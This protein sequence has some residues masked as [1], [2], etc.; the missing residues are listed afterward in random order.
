M[1]IV[2]KSFD[3]TSAEMMIISHGHYD[4]GEQS[5]MRRFLLSRPTWKICWSKLFDGQVNKSPI[6]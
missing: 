2:G 5:K 3:Y 4:A 6:T 1:N